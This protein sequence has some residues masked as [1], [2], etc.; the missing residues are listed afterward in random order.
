MKSLGALIIIMVLALV[1]LAPPQEPGSI[2]SG[3]RPAQDRVQARYLVV[4]TFWN[5]ESHT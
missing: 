3:Q 1:V 2:T 4:N 5:V